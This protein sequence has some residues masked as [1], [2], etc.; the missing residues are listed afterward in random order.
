MEDRNKYIDQKLRELAGYTPN[1]KADWEAF[2]LNNQS[3]IDVLKSGTVKGTAGRLIGS[4]GFKYTI[5][6]ISVIAV[7]VAAYFITSDSGSRNNEEMKLPEIQIIRQ[8]EVIVPVESSSPQNIPAE[9]AKK[10]LK[11]VDETNN[12][13]I[14]DSKIQNPDKAKKV[15]DE[16]N[17]PKVPEVK[18]AVKKTV[19]DSTTKKP[20]IIKK[21]VI[22]QDTIRIKRPVGK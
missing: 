7:F 12:S 1:V 18:E 20:V 21:T 15:I 4:S 3:G 22:I 19:N 17:Q 6:A 16:M 11:P 13:I 8:N 2:Y 14:L 10:I 5:I 9:P